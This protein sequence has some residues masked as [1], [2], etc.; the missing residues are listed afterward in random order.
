MIRSWITLVAAFVALLAGLLALALSGLRA[1]GSMPDLLD[2]ALDGR[3]G[4]LL[5][6]LAI[7]AAVAALLVV[8]AVAL[9]TLASDNQRSRT[10]RRA[11]VVPEVRQAPPT[12]RTGDGRWI[13]LSEGCVEVIDELDQNLDGFDVQS[14]ALAEHVSLRLEEVLERSGVAVIKDEANFDRAR[15]KSV[16]GGGETLVGAT[17]SETVSPGFAVGQRVLRRARVR[18]ER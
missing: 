2:R 18:V 15:H 5:L 16:R 12:D 8:I 9:L 6:L 14:R 3:F 1:A 17:I 13:K 11:A 7:G 4:D 10:T